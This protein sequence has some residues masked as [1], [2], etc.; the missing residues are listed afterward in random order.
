M[1]L[2]DVLHAKKLPRSLQLVIDEPRLLASLWRRVKGGDDNAREK[3]FAYYQELALL[4]SRREYSRRPSYGLDRTDFDQLAFFGLLQAIDRYDPSSGCTFKTFAQYRISGAIA[5]GVLRSSE[6]AS[7]YSSV[8][9][10]E[11]D[12]LNSLASKP[13]LLEPG[14]SVESLRDLVINLAVSVL[15]ESVTRETI[16]GVEDQVVPN[17]YESLRFNQICR[18]L[19]ESI[20]TMPE[21]QK[22]VVNR[23]YFEDMSFT[24]IA[25]IMRLTKGRISQIHSMAIA[26]LRR[27]LKSK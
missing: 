12:R 17:A 14:K 2:A 3:L 19:V 10:A 7:V 27:R 20:D 16:E 6:K 25:E 1:D 8:R 4:M 9:R 13:E 26:Y 18:I 5:D 21:K 24:L 15:V 23:H 11:R 22:Q